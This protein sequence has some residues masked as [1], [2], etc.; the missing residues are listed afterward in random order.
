[1]LRRVE[2]RFFKSLKRVCV[3][4]EP[5]NVLAGPNSS[6]KS[7]FLDALVFLKD[8]LISEEGAHEAVTRRARSMNEVVWKGEVD[9]FE[10]RVDAELPGDIAKHLRDRTGRAYGLIRY[11]IRV[12]TGSDGI[13]PDREEL[14][15]VESGYTEPECYG[16]ERSSF[17]EDR[18]AEPILPESGK[19]LRSPRGHTVV[20]RRQQYGSRVYVLSEITRKKKKFN[21]GLDTDPR[22]SVL[23]VILEDVE[24]FK[25]SLWFRRLLRDN[26]LFIHLNTDAMRK[27][28]PPDAPE[29]FIPDG[30][31]LAKVV[32]LLKSKHPDRFSWWLK[33]VTEF[34]KDI[35]GIDVGTLPE[36]NFLYLRVRYRYGV[37]T[38][39]WL[40]SDGTLR[41][42]ALSVIPYLPP[43]RRVFMIE[44]P[45]NGLHPLA[46]EGVFQSLKSGR[47]SEHQ[48]LVATHSPVFLA[49]AELSDLLI[50]RK[51]DTGATDIVR[52]TRHPKLRNRK[53]ET[54]LDSLF[55]TGVL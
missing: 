39:S 29:R 7:N 9:S 47:T 32:S 44:E 10:I 22:R 23:S 33:H 45:E 12:A 21:L 1:M 20:A 46:I 34:L 52:G 37:D 48:I 24:R 6:G 28:V 14:Y 15:L 8:M 35:E 31:N 54:L 42:L 3:D 40:L 36:N 26:L 17:P 19:K 53:R 2:V 11:Q 49:L 5:F 4:L 13:G 41:F 51:T 50:F 27:P 18:K 16:G 38:P 55:A 43:D 25:A 30:S